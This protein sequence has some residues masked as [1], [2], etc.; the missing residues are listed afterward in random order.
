M[1]TEKYVVNLVNVVKSNFK[2]NLIESIA[3]IVFCD[4]I[5][6]QRKIEEEDT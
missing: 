6:M 5:T 3:I 4:N 1:M 2:R